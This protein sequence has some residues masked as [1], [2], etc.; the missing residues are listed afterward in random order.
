MPRQPTVTE[1]C[2]KN[3]T[4]CLTPT[5]SL[6]NELNAAFA[7]P[8]VQPILNTVSSLLKLVPNVKQNKKECAEML[9]NMHQ[10]LFAIINLYIKSEAAGS[11]TPAIM[12]H[13]GTFMKTLHKIYIYI[14]AQQ[15]RNKLRQLFRNIEMNNLVKNC[16][17][18]LDEAKKNFGIGT[19]AAVF[20]D[21]EE[22]NKAAETKH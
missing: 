9:E 4:T 14:E 8:F 10:V 20:K 6:L 18:E 1:I 11:L 12:E 22:M 21:I 2:L 17:A 16:H 3:L 15:D 19:G 5:V 13:V 7:P